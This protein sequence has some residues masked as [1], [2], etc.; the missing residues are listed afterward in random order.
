MISDANRTLSLSSITVDRPN[1]AIGATITR[2][3]ANNALFWNDDTPTG[4]LTSNFA[5]SKGVVAFD[6]AG[7]GFV[8]YHSVPKFPTLVT[9]SYPTSG[10]RFG[11]SF[12]CVTVNS[13]SVSTILNGLIIS[14]PQVYGSPAPSVPA[15]LSPTF[16][17]IVARNFD[18]AP[19]AERLSF[20]SGRGVAF[21]LFAKTKQWNR[22]LYE[23]IVASALGGIMC[24][25]WLNDRSTTLPSS[26]VPGQPVYNI[27]AMTFVA[28]SWTRLSDHSKWCVALAANSFCVGGV[29]HASTQAGRGG[30]TLCF[31][32]PE[33][34][35]IIYNSVNTVNPCGA[36]TGEIP[37][38]RSDATTG[39]NNPP[40][41]SSNL[42]L[43]GLL[44][45]LVLVVAAVV[46]VVFLYYRKKSQGQSQDLEQPLSPD[47]RQSSVGY[48][49][50]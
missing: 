29:N 46:L 13:A 43:L 3:Y 14:G 9:Y 37:A 50:L 33:I 42:A 41:S 25:T 31:S 47:S 44:A 10:E 21:S 48:S 18:T 30:E 5:H 38:P 8:L 24:Q 15:N 45:L 19:K 6:A 7:N 34:S 28:N 20:T 4:S 39:N 11:Q 23:G 40:P 17:A 1:G 27:H 12:I 16:Q 49:D 22:D 2:A 32:V 35:R 26:C 36:I